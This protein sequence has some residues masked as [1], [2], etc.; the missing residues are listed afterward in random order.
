MKANLKLK[1]LSLDELLKFSPEEIPVKISGIINTDISAQIDDD[2]VKA[3]GFLAMPEA[4]IED[5]AMNFNLPF[6]W[7][8]ARLPDGEKIF[9][10]NNATLNTQAASLNFSTSADIKN[11]K[12]LAKGQARNISL[13]EIGKIFAPDLNLRGTGGNL[14]FDIDTIASG[15][16]LSNTRADIS[17][18][19]P[20]ISAMGMKILENLAAKINLAKNQAPK[21]DATGRIF[22]G[23]LFAR[24]QVDAKDFK[25]EFI[26]S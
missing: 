1:S 22:G 23:K 26:V 20:M 21:I 18:N 8:G 15:D 3:S 11:L 17:A 9:S 14:D 13:T 2:F 12:I 7:D 16:I 4:V 19:M 6:A 10:L 25:P 5:I 24:G